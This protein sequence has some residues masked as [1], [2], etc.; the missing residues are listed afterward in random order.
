M[1]KVT[2][3]ILEKY[4]HGLL[5]DTEARQVSRQ[6]KSDTKLFEKYIE[7]KE[8]MFLSTTGQ[9][10]SAEQ[11]KS[12]MSMLPADKPHLQI[13]LSFLKEQITISTSD[14]DSL[15]YQGIQANFAFRNSEPGPVAITRKIEGRNIT[16][17]IT[18]SGDDSFRLALTMD[19]PEKLRVALHLNGDSIEELS[20]LK[21]QSGFDSVIPRTGS[22]TLYFYKKKELLFTVGFKLHSD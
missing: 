18:P 4:I 5:S 22:L 7:F 16:F 9:K 17:L 20:N 6:L 19:P 21:K 11:K 8:V 1:I 3:E 10:P 13:L 12:I 15:E 14:T 2:D